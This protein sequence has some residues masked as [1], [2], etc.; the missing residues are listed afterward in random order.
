MNKLFI[1]I[2]TVLSFAALASDKVKIDGNM[3]LNG[4]LNPA[5]DGQLTILAGE[6]IEIKDG[7]Q[8]KKMYKIN[9]HREGIKDIWIVPIANIEGGLPLNGHFL[10]KGYVSV[11]N[12]LDPSK[13]LSKLINSST[14]LLAYQVNTHK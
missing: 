6:I 1:L 2:L 14:I 11:A 9:L 8:N 3:I 7:P 5:Y 4:E 12:S 13:N 10:F